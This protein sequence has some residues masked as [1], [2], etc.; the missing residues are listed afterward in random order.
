MTSPEQRFRMP[1]EWAPHAATWL[2]WPHNRDTWPEGLEQV[3]AALVDG[4]AALA[5]GEPVH[6]NVRDPDHAAHVGGLFASRVP[7]DTVVLEPIPTND[8]W[9]RD[10]GAIIVEDEAGRRVA[11]DFRYNAWGGKYPPYDLDD[12][13]PRHM[14]QALG[15]PRISVDMV[16]EGGSIDVNGAGTL[17]TTEQCLLNPNRNPTLTRAG[18]EGLLGRYLGA[19]QVVWLGEGIAGDDTDGH[20][21]DLTRFVAQD[22]VVTAVEADPADVNYNPL[23]ENFERLRSLRL[24]DGRAVQVVALPMPHPVYRN[25]E[26]LPASYA[27]FYI[28][29][30]AVL[31]PV[32][33]CPQDRAAVE[34]LARCLPDRRIVPIDSR[35][36]VVGLGAFHCLTQQVP[37]RRSR[38]S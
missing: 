14:A 34:R 15:L 31:A 7:P 2:S 35:A 32:F 38:P 8:A 26:R 30:R 21:D 37:A 27:N 10:H 12:A 5:E 19:R 33:G 20:V 24:H 6:I 16:L 36:L 13:V 3:E 11:L 9:C 17:L 22:V 29:N 4:V 25:G 18:I 1:P 23:R 28:G